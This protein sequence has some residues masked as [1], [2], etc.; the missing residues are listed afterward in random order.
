MTTR[1][2]LLDALL[3][4]FGDRDIH[5]GTPLDTVAVHYGDLIARFS[6]KHPEVGDASV[7]GVLNEAQPAFQTI[8]SAAVSVGDIC[9]YSFI[10]F[11][12]HLDR[13]RRIQRVAGDVI[14]FLQELFADRLL[15]WKSVDGLNPGWRERG[16]AGHVD[17]LVLDDRTYRRWLWSG[18]LSTWRATL[19]ILAHGRILDD[20]EHDILVMRLHATGPAGFELEAERALARRLVADYEREGSG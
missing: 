15:L 5:L 13:A 8:V 17:P 6:A 2:L 12:V 14:R 3:E 4:H 16:E 11:D 9:H 20:R 1:K 18:P 19:K 7:W 10:N